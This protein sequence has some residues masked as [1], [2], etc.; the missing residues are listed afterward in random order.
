MISNLY[1]VQNCICTCKKS[2]KSD[3]F[4]LFEAINSCILAQ[5]AGCFEKICGM[6]RMPQIAT[7]SI[8]AYT[9]DIFRLPSVAFSQK[10][11]PFFL[12]FFQFFSQNNTFVD[13]WWRALL[14]DH[15]GDSTKNFHQNNHCCWC[16]LKIVAYTFIFPCLTKIFFSERI[17]R[18]PWEQNNK[19]KCQISVHC[20]WSY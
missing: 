15:S 3:Q 2:N 6:H 10:R 20:H 19:N 12:S 9:Y 17:S 13:L 8:V 4:T 16:A 7:P 1:L 18:D 5:L 14:S 11:D